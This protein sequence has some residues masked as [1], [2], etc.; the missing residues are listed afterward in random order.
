MQIR[1]KGTSRPDPT[2]VMR[3]RNTD[4]VLSFLKILSVFMST[5]NMAEKVLSLLTF[6]CADV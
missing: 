3:I 5:R 6:G 2:K 1:I 4:S